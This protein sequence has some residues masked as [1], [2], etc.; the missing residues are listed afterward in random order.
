MDNECTK[1][2]YQKRVVFFID[3]LGFKSLIEGD[4]KKSADEI[5][6]LLNKIKKYIYKDEVYNNREV[7]YF[8]DSIVISFNYDSPSEL[9]SVLI[10]LLHLQLNLAA[11]DNVLIRG[12]CNL[13]DA[14]H[15][16]NVIYGIAINEAY[17]LETK[18]AIYPRI[19][20]SEEII[21]KCSKHSIHNG[22]DD[23]D[24]ILKLLEQDTDGYYYIDYL[25][26]DVAG[27]E[28]NDN[29]EW[30][31]YIYDLKDFIEEGLK[32]K[33]ISVKQKYQW[34]K[35]KYNKALTDNIIENYK[36]NKIT[37]ERID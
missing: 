33:N 14:V 12:A 22:Y 4:C 3:I 17:K 37:L 24:D 13:G 8:S 9:F 21:N 20:V 2:E 11:I 23:K 27:W 10:N 31:R 34:L 28:M 6:I 36:K 7:T 18:C 32:Q 1:V 16:E 19:I 26:Y 5:T 35:D 29:E 25:S 15:N 30:A